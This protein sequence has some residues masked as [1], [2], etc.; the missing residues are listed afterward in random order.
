VQ[1]KEKGK[2]EGRSGPGGW[3]LNQGHKPLLTCTWEEELLCPSG[4]FSNVST[5]L[6][7]HWTLNKD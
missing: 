5:N 7:T 1:K 4:M 2:K 6:V 3:H